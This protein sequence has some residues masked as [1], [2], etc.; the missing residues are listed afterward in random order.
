MLFN[1]SSLR[2]AIELLFLEQTFDSL[3]AAK[4]FVVYMWHEPITLNKIDLLKTS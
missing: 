4:R 2:S 3:K 1:L